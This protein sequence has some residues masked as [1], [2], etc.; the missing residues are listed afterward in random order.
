MGGSLLIATAILIEAASSDPA[1]VEIRAPDAPETAVLSLHRLE[2]GSATAQPGMFGSLSRGPDGLGFRPA[3]RLTPGETYRALLTADNRELA[4]RDWT[5]PVP[6]APSPRV[7][8]VRPDAAVLP[9]NLLKFYLHFSEPMRESRTVFDHFHL[10]RSDGSRVPDPW[11]RQ[12]L[13]SADG[14]RL[15]LWVHPG[16]VKRGVNLR[17]ELGPVLEPGHAYALVIEPG[18]QSLAG[19]RVETG[20]RHLFRTGPENHSRP[21]PAAW[22]LGVPRAGTSD[23]LEIGFGEPVDHALA[24]RHLS[25]ILMDTAKAVPASAEVLSGNTRVRLHPVSPWSAGPHALAVGPWLEDLAGNTPERVF[26][27][28]LT[29]G[30]PVPQPAEI[31]FVIRVAKP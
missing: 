13:W 23:A 8:S 20:F 19:R 6:E 22:S 2:P 24:A 25:L 30:P 27:H 21:N 31:R 28:D 5:V 10:E 17:E 3:F 14:T 29:E 7:L 26:D 1:R 11:R 4:R 15:T 9:A 16:R 18:M 12:E